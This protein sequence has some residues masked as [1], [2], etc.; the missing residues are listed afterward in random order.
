MFARKLNE[1]VLPIIVV[2]IAVAVVSFLIVRALST[3]VSTVTVSQP[4]NTVQIAPAVAVEDTGMTI[5][6]VYTNYQSAGLAPNVHIYQASLNYADYPSRHSA[7]QETAEFLRMNQQ[8][9]GLADNWVLYQASLN[10]ADYVR[11]PLSA[12]PLQGETGSGPY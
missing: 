6:E 12:L 5:E 2:A 9:S 10:Y 7:N 8:A 4:S 1:W 3:Q 11:E